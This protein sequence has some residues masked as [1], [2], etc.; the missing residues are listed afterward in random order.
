[1]AREFPG[2]WSYN[3]WM[4]LGL[5]CHLTFGTPCKAEANFLHTSC[6]ATTL[7]AGHKKHKISSLKALRY[8]PVLFASSVWIR[9]K[10]S[11]ASCFEIVLL[12]QELLRDT[13]SLLVFVR[14]EETT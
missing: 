1:M 6:P 4:L 9:V 2:D 5:T 7:S 14:S 13:Y 12:S 10:V 11:N 8:D 3:L